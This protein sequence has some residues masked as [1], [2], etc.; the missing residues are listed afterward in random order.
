MEVVLSVD[1]EGNSFRKIP[2]G[3][4]GVGSFTSDM[5]LI[6]EEEIGEFSPEDLKKFLIIG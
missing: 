3:W 2:D 6:N 4:V 1:E 5:E